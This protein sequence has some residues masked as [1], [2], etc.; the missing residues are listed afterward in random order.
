MRSS[1]VQPAS[2]LCLTAGG[3]TAE[4]MGAS[5]KGLRRKARRR[6][7]GACAIF[8]FFFFF[9]RRNPRPRTFGEE[10]AGRRVA[11]REPLLAHDEQAAPLRVLLGAVRARIVFGVGG[12]DPRARGPHLHRG[13]APL[14]RDGEAVSHK[15]NFRTV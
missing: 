11:L 15:V 8:F 9:Y 12:G 14:R 4:G 7:R 3:K 5:G 6:V 10:D 2:L 13:R 1:A